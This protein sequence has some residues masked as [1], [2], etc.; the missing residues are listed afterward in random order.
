MVT[1]S[2]R[3]FQVR[4]PTT[5]KARL[6]T[7]VNLTG[8]TVYRLVPAERR[9]RRPGK[10]TTHVDQN[11]KTASPCKTSIPS[12]FNTWVKEHKQLHT[13]SPA[14]C[15]LPRITFQRLIIRVQFT[16]HVAVTIYQT[17]VV[18]DT[19][20]CSSRTWMKCEHYELQLST[21]SSLANDF[22][23]KK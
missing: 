8:G 16:S 21:Y 14:G 11:P 18:L 12:H 10:S 7:V 22:R 4:G 2:D 5:R 15:V 17:C 9:G 1:S 20:Q 19:E 13:T 6:P 23:N 3:S